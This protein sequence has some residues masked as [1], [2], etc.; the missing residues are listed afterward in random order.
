MCIRDRLVVLPFHLNNSQI[1]PCGMYATTK[2]EVNNSVSLLSICI[3][4]AY[5]NEQNVLYLPVLKIDFYWSWCW[6]RFIKWKLVEFSGAVSWHSYVS[7]NVD[8]Q[9]M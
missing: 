2:L 3:N 8:K 7:S 5:S 1:T 9:N 6:K 4:H